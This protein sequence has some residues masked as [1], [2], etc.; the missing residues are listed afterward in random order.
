MATTSDS[1]VD[2][3][4]D[5][6]NDAKQIAEDAQAKATQSLDD[7]GAAVAGLRVDWQ[8]SYVN[9]DDVVPE[10][11][12]A[13][14]LPAGDFSSDVRGAFDY[15]FGTL[16]E[17]L[18][19]QILN[20]LETFFPDIADAV[21]TSSDEWIAGTIENGRYVPIDVENALWNRA[22]DREMQEALRAEQSI[23]EASAARG[24]STPPGTAQ[25]SVTA[26]RE[27]LS[28]K[29]ATINRE[30]AVK[31]FDTANENTKFAIEQAVRLRTAFVSALG[32]FIKV[33][34]VQPNQA[35]DYAK[36]ILAAKTGL[37]DSAVGLYRANIEQERMRTDVSLQNKGLDM[38]SETD[39]VDGRYKA[40]SALI[41]MAK[42]KA[43]A[44]M[45]AADTLAKIAQ[46][47]M[48][49]RNTMI[50]IAAGV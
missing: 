23:L 29:L 1:L 37:Y 16:N 41:E 47:A 30:I 34:M 7:A 46:A 4:N 3:A 42:V 9:P 6:Y 28:M 35:I 48:A 12:P 2:E 43:D 40:T 10:R 11:I 38:K 8:T 33:S 49:T 26:A 39:W 21:K 32:D 25:A 15:A 14:V 27:E 50:S 18:Q 13:P 24:F 31:A 45:S 44:A 36:T 17:S 5:S 22:K 20:Y 19:P